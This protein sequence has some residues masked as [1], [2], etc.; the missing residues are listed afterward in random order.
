[1]DL[2]R[3]QFFL[4]G[5]VALA[6]GIQFRMVESYVLNAESTKFVAEKFGA[7]AQ[8]VATTT[9][10]PSMETAGKGSSVALRSVKPPVWLGWATI[11]I[12]A[13]LILHSL[14]MTKP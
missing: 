14:A 5:L 1:M 3:N 10:I 4:I 12:G 9:F 7:P 11:S 6:L 13:V 8:Q 2:N